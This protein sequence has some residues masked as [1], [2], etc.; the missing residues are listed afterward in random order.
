MKKML[1]TVA[2]LVIMVFAFSGETVQAAYKERTDEYALDSYKYSAYSDD[3]DIVAKAK[4]ITAGITDD[5]D[6]VYA[7]Y[8]WVSRNVEYTKEKPN[9]LTGLDRWL[10]GDCETYSSLTMYLAQ[11]SGFPAKVVIGKLLGVPGLGSHAW[12]EVYVDDRW[13]LIDSTNNVFDKP[14]STW[15]N[16]YA[17]YEYSLRTQDE[18]AWDGTL[19]FYDYYKDKDV[20]EIKNFPLNGL[21][22]DTYGFDIDTLFF[23]IEYTQPFKL[24]T[25]RVNSQNCV[26]FVNSELAAKTYKITFNSNGGSTVK[27]V[28]V[29]ANAKITKPANPTRK[30][31]KFAG[32][33]KDNKCTKKWDFAKDKVTKN[34]TLYAKWKKV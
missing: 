15:D 7:I 29:K 1:L 17:N 31:Y 3:P 18:E 16:S 9:G 19:Y 32:W 6:K 2:V 5:Y 12:T 4:E 34:I 30:G 22:T 10:Y 28:K 21:V 14:R 27:A 13:I 8:D 23:D 11:A 26:I 33:Y 24:N 20:K 25:M